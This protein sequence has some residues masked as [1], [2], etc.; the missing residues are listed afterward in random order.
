MLALTLFMP[1]LAFAED[2]P[3]SISVLSNDAKFIGTSIGGMEV[4]LRDPVSGKI[5]AQGMVKGSTG[6]TSLIMADSLERDAV[7]RT[8]GS[9]RFNTVLDMDK[10]Q[11][12]EISVYGPV[13]QAQSAMELKEERILIPG[14]DYTKGN[15]IIL[16][17]PGMSVDVL[18]PAAHTTA[19]FDP[20]GD[21]SLRANVMKMCGCPV[22]DKDPWSFKR[23]D[24]AAHIYKN[25]EEL[26][27]TVPLIYA[28]LASQFEASLQLPEPGTYEIIVTAFDPKTKDSGMDRTTIVLSTQ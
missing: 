9:A 13:A 18:T 8:E 10:P 20:D 14:K 3:V 25:G 28:G 1:I 22:Q 16:T 21:V 27:K 5:L 17:M 19:I 7:L 4:M 24:V 12:V 2:T 6:D 15:G 11:K 26:I 23:Y